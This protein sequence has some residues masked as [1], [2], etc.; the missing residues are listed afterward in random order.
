V[1]VYPALSDKYLTLP[2]SSYPVSEQPSFD[3]E[4]YVKNR[5]YL[6]PYAIQSGVGSGVSKAWVSTDDNEKILRE[7]ERYQKLIKQFNLDG[8]AT[9]LGGIPDNYPPMSWE[10]EFPEYLYNSVAKYINSYKCNTAYLDTFSCV[11]TTSDYNPYYNLNGSTSAGK[12][13]LDWLKRTVKKLRENNS[14]INI[15]SEGACDIY[16][17]YLSHMIASMFAGENSNIYRYAFPDQIIFQG[18]VSNNTRAE[19][20]KRKDILSKAFLNGCKLDT[21]LYG[22]KRSAMS[23]FLPF[24]SKVL[25]LRQMISP[26]LNYAVYKDTDGISLSDSSIVGYSHVISEATRSVINHQGSKAITITVR[27]PKNIEGE[28]SC[29]IPE[30]IVPKYAYIAELGNEN[31]V[32]L[33]FKVEHGNLIFKTS[34]AELSAAIFIDKALGECEW[35]ARITQKDNNTLIANIYNF[36]HKPISVS[37]KATPENSK[38]NDAIRELNISNGKRAIAMFKNT[39]AVPIDK[40]RLVKVTISSNAI[41]RTYVSG[42]GDCS[43][44]RSLFEYGK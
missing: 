7:K 6:S 38:I 34:K 2:W 44:E 22:I 18:G 3:W 11:G 33:K 31:L 30:G 40:I 41:E 14:S 8:R 42:F 26:F 43:K 39:E 12:Q 29:L 24:Q 19:A 13:R 9:R 20:N 37:V 17:I 16:G 25:R 27:N 1:S 35:T 23:E 10:G 32:P 28:V 21:S 36:A 5:L 4:W 15:L